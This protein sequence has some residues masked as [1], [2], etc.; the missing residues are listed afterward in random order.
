[1]PSIDYDVHDI[2]ELESPVFVMAFKGLFD[3]G[4]SAT[5]AV[6]WLSM[7]YS[8]QP[9]ASIDPELLFDFQETRPE[10]RLGRSGNREILWPSNN[11]VWAKTEPGVPDLVL[12]S[13][14]EPN[15]R[16][17]SFSMVICELYEKMGCSM[18]VTLGAALGMVPHTRAFPV[19][20]STG[21][22]ELSERLAIG[23]P[24]YEGPTGLAGSLHEMFSNR[25]IP[26]VALSVSVPHYVPGPPSPKSTAALLAA[27]E[28][29]LSIPTAHAGLA[30]EIRDWEARVHRALD[31]DEDVKDYVRDLEQRK[32]DEPEVLD[33]LDFEIAIEDFLGDRL[34]DDSGSEEES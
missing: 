8:G 24:S 5:A 20:A 10:I 3:M 16:W 34:G 21:D 6:D 13:G 12:L 17:R 18:A 9:A 4:G 27:F 15:L 11:L 33:D 32:D 23:R 7:T 28:R 22:R 26:A 14:V 19:R 30:D 31:D 1:M 29:Y 25:D 2:G